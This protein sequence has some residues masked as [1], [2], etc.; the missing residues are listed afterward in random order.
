MRVIDW[1]KTIILLLTIADSQGWTNSQ[2]SWHGGIQQRGHVIGGARCKPLWS[3]SGSGGPNRNLSA[4]GKERRDEEKRRIQRKDDVVP[5]KTS[6][7]RGATDYELNSKATEEEW[8]R[9]ASAVDKKVFRLTEEG[10]ESL[11]MVCSVCFLFLISWCCT[12]HRLL[13]L[14]IL[15]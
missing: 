14:D 13:A 11:K 15:Y 8:L 4:A 10:M 3:S 7:L 2:F 12:V 1:R 5:G 6:A 9:Q